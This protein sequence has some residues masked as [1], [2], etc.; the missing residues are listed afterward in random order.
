MESE[1]EAEILG[2]PIEEPK[3]MTHIV[4]RPCSV[5]DS[6]EQVDIIP[7]KLPPAGLALDTDVLLTSRTDPLTRTQFQEMLDPDGR[8]VCEHQLRKAVFLGGVCPEIRREVW[9][10]LFGLYPCSSTTREREAILL[11]YIVRYHEMKSRWK[12]LLVVNSPP[13]STPLEQCLT[14]RYLLP[15]ESS[16]SPTAT[17]TQPVPSH[18]PS[19]STR[20]QPLH[21][22]DVD[23]AFP[24]ENTNT[25]NDGRIDL[26]GLGHPKLAQQYSTPDMS[27]KLD[28]M[29][30]QAQ[31]QVN[32]Q[33]MDVQN[34]RTNIRVIDKDVPRTDR[35]VLFFSGRNNPHLRE[36]RDILVTFAAYNGELG[37]AQGMNDILSR[38]LYVMG[39]EVET[40]WC[41]RTYMEKIGSDFMEEGMTYKIDLVRMLLE[42]MD[43]ALL[44]HLETTDLGNLFFC[45]RW[46]LL[47]FKREFSFEDSLRCFEILS[48]HHLEL[49]SLE[50]EKAVLREERKEF[51]STGGD[52]RTS[53]L[54]TQKEYT[55]EVF[56]CATVLTECRD[57][58]FAC[59]DCGQVFCF[60]NNLTFDLDSLLTKSERL[61]FVYCKKTVGESFQLVDSNNSNANNKQGFLSYFFR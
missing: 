47:G 45:H 21:D 15:E 23:Q 22:A 17:T 26:K 61:F 44:K 52:T 40:Y 34:L 4:Q 38:F 5:D 16:P 3:N 41:F 28:F 58:F 36:L 12:T 27:Q 1:E 2:F 59:T 48:S 13:N 42:E 8:L 37:Y 9:A 29:R 60:L 51:A 39:S 46:L 24:A 30:L 25:K 20:S 18:L 19:D 33:K 35:D 31:V 55:F 10:F 14:A 43:P 11:D 6:F 54:A 32:R 7:S 53:G 57:D 49:S 56:M 50:A